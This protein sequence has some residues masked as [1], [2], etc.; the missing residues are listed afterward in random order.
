MNLLAPA[1]A[2]GVIISLERNSPRYV[3]LG[4][5]MSKSCSIPSFFGHIS[6]MGK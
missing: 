2:L 3:A 6:H 4:G 1:L 5:L